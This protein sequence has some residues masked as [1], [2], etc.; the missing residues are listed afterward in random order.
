[1]ERSCEAVSLAHWFDLRRDPPAWSSAY[2]SR[3]SPL[4]YRYFLER[5][6]LWLRWVVL[7]ISCTLTDLLEKRRVLMREWSQYVASGE[8][9]EPK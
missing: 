9:K 7:A 1:M 4:P 3:S 2:V 8:L 5:M 6:L